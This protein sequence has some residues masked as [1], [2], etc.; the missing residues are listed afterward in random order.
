MTRDLRRELVATQEMLALVLLKSGP[1][2]V[3]KSLLQTGLD[4]KEIEIIDDIEGKAFVFRLV[5][6]N[7]SA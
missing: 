1:V 2:R 7:E 4:N 3:E 6:K 5:D